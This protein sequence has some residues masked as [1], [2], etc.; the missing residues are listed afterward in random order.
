MGT[1]DGFMQVAFTLYLI[2]LFPGGP[3]VVTNTGTWQNASDCR[4]AADA[5]AFVPKN[6]QGEQVPSI[7]FMCVPRSGFGPPIV[8]PRR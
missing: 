2:V 5:A 3:P 1:K 7:S 8:S 4:N 6:T